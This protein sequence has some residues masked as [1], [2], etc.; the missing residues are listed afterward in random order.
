MGIVLFQI[1]QFDIIFYVYVC[2]EV[3]LKR[4]MQSLTLLT[5]SVIAIE[6]ICLSLRLYIEWWSCLKK[7]KENLIID[8]G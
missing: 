8:L 2:K 5:H 7:T 4:L 3:N 6:Q 1:I